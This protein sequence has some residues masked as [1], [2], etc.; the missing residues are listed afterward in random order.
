MQTRRRN[1]SLVGLQKRSLGGACRQS[2]VRCQNLV[3][4]IMRHEGINIHLA[5][6]YGLCQMPPMVP[7]VISLLAIS[8]TDK[9]S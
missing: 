3:D 9:P 6:T 5:R 7:T 2:T 4:G 8:V 1:I